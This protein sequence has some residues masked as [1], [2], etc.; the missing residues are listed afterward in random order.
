MKYKLAVLGAGSMGIATAILLNGNGH[1]VVV[2]SPFKEEA[3]NLIKNRENKDKLPGIIIP[4]SINILTDIKKATANKDIIILAIPAQRVRETIRKIKDEI[5]KNTIFVCC[6]KGIEEKSKALMTEVI[7]EELAFVNIVAL[8]GPSHAEE[9][10]A[11]MPTAVVAASKS[12]ECAKIVQNIFMNDYFR[13]YTNSDVIGV[14]LG[15]AIKNVIAL[16]A[17]IS[18]GLGFGDNSKAA[19]MTRGIAE[20]QRLGEK[21]GAKAETFAGLTGVGDLIVT[22]TSMLSR[23]RRAGILIGKG[24]KIDDVLKDIGMVVEGYTTVKPL[25]ELAKEKN[26]SMPITKEAYEI[27]YNNKD[28]MTAVKELMQRGKKHE[29]ERKNEKGYIW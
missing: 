14:E 21:M 29:I 12:E 24:K 5:N 25:L 10:A 22:C 13:V 1:E 20:I 6:S 23:N 27:L 11:R 7:K 2:W 9:I 4:K 15:G 16:C 19:L 17:G 8:S 18:D 3:D 26:V 28:P